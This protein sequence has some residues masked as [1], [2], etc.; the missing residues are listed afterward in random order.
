MANES[1]NDKNWNPFAPFTGMKMPNVDISKLMSIHQKN[2][3]TLSSANKVAAEI[4][5]S[6]AQL[7]AKF[8]RQA[9]DDMAIV[10]REAAGWMQNP[11]AA[12][13]KLA[14][15]QDLVKNAVDKV[16]SHNKNIGS[17]ISESGEKVI[18]MFQKRM[19]DNWNEMTDMIQKASK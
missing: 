16:V 14:G 17:S 8:M 15:A 3:E 2:M 7:Q 5:Q 19:S 4:T 9:M 11:S 12:G 6:I 18:Q 1:S 10:M 13:E